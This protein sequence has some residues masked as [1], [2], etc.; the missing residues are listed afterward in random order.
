VRLR[1]QA[2]IDRPI[3]EVFAFVSDPMN[4]PEW[5]G[6]VKA[7]EQ[8]AGDGPAVGARYREMHDPRPGKAVPLELEIREL[9]PPLRMVLFEEDFAAQ[10]HVTYELDA[11]DA[12]RTRITQT[13]EVLLKGLW[14]LMTPASY[15]GIR[16]TLPKQFAALKAHLESRAEQPR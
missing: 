5:C 6:Y 9:D 10:L 16:M 8:T 1:A 11:L 13:S 2:T 3:D 7:A 12:D 15:L 14:K 4:D